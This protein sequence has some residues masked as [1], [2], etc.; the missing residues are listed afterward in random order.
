MPISIPTDI[1]SLS[2]LFLSRGIP[3]TDIG[4]YNHPGFLAAERE[5]VT[6][7]EHYGA[8][9]RARPRDPDYEDHVRA[10]VPKMAAVL[11]EEI[12][13]DGQLGVCIDAAMMLSKML[14][15]QGIWNYAAKGALSI[16]APGLSSP[17]HFWLY[18][19]EPAAGHAWIV[20]PPF[21]IV[22]VALKSQPY[23]RGEASYLPAALVS[24]AGRPIKP[25]AHEYVSAEIIAREYA[26]RGTISRDLHFQIAPA[27]KTVTSRFPSWEVSAGKA[28]LRY[29]VGGVTLSDGATVYDITSRTWNG[30][31]AG[32]LYDH[33]VLPALSAPPGAS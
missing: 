3:T 24:E 1:S 10:I 16:G 13:R 23:Q 28:T 29:A 9:V 17:T 30:R 26:R 11:A 7:L 4:F 31:S 5:D 21:E 33:I 8:W 25:E 15:E 22:D 18:D 2:Q 14:E 6:F 12:L 27:L 20:A 32:E 19:T